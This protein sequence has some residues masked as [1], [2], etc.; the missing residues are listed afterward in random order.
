[1]SLPKPTEHSGP[2][3][4]HVR[5]G[6]I[7]QSPIA[8]SGVLN[9]ADWVRDD[10]PDLLWPALYLAHEGTTS[11]AKAIVHWQKDV[12]EGTN[13][14]VDTD[15]EFIASC[16]DGR[17][18]GLDR[19]VERL[20]EAKE[21]II[22][23]VAERGLLPAPVE[24]A[25]ATYL[26]RPAEWL[27]TLPFAPPD[28]EDANLLAKAVR[29]S[30]GDGHREAVLKCLSIWAAVHAGT[31]R[32]D[33]KTVD[34]LR[35]YPSDERTRTE[36]DSVIRALWGASRGAALIKTP[37]LSDES[38]R[39]A[40]VFWNVN[41][42]AM[43]CIR[44]RDLPRESDQD[45]GQSTDAMEAEDQPATH[46]EPLRLHDLELDDVD[47]TW[48][49]QQPET[50]D[51]APSD[52]RQRAIDLLTSYIEALDVSPSRLYDPTPQ[53][54]HAGLVTRAGREVITALGLPDL[55]CTEHGSHIGRA[56]VE[57]R[58][59]LTWM[60]S[61][62][63]EIYPK[64][65]DYGAGKAKL[66]SRIVKEVPAEWLID[67]AS[68][69]IDRLHKASH[70]DDLFDLVTVDTRSTFADGKSLREMA[71]EVGL[72]DLYRHTY[73]LSSGVS[74]MEFW[75]VEMHSLER[76]LNVLHRGH[77]IP[78]LDLS[79]GGNIELARAWVIALYG[80]IR[81]SLQIL[82]TSERAVTEAFSWLQSNEG[83]D[84]SPESDA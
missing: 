65:K 11:A 6:R 12:L 8:A 73:Q 80:L 63:P 25:L 75:S 43:G 2:L 17:L 59:T 74:H 52:L 84:G 5:K 28:L 58:I 66:Y 22:R 14:W 60:A 32:T 57:A 68:E 40:K 81:L 18:S 44:R 42:I 13:A 10:L 30:I 55:W 4:G 45:G 35:H 39:W 36:A 21:L 61:Q 26:D 37:D 46:A 83:G 24:K 64:F 70:S 15:P 47:A 23:T 77:L 48:L 82:G 29:E 33:K 51:V 53:E 1:M 54:V 3:A 19:L 62:G 78:N 49:A 41:S 72:L 56:V 67:G 7:F 9:L 16:L 50:A 34:L 71:S 38:I 31:F 27:I 20:P 79:Y 69:A 76:C